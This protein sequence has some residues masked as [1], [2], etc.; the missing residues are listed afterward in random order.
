MT[1]DEIIAEKLNDVD[2]IAKGCFASN[3]KSV[4]ASGQ[5]KG[6]RKPCCYVLTPQDSHI[7]RTFGYCGTKRCPFYKKNRQEIRLDD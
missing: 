6:S 7:M 1:V 2:R 5:D 4:F 3:R